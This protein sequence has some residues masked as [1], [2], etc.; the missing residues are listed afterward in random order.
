MDSKIKLILAGFIF[1]S[2]CVMA[3]GKKQVENPYGNLVGSLSDEEAYAFLVM[4]YD[5]NVMVTSDMIYD[6]GTERQASTYCD[7]YYYSSGEAKNIG[8]IMSE[9][10]AYPLSFSENGIFAASGHSIEKYMISERDGLLYMEKG[11]YETFDESGKVS[12]T[13]IEDGNETSS[14]EK[15]YQELQNEYSESQII[16]FS[17]GASGCVNEI[18]N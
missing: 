1:I 2:I 5:N 12:Y 17:Y 11:I 6:A 4:D 9:G 16:H 18:M 15:E 14:T 13:K 8:S 3:C 7:L 10:T